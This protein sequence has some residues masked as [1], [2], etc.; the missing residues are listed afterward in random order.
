MQ[1]IDGI[2]CLGVNNSVFSQY[3]SNQLKRVV[4]SHE[5][6]SVVNSSRRWAVLSAILKVTSV[7][8]PVVK[9]TLPSRC[10]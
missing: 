8:L 9:G 1:L 10:S 2:G 5:M 7:T 6:G 3:L 4:L